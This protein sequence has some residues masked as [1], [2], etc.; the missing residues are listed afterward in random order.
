MKN[1]KKV[2]LID[3]LDEINRVM[4]ENKSLFVRH[5]VYPSAFIQNWS[6]RLV[7]DWISKQYF[8]T[9]ERKEKQ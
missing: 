3:S 4:K 7:S 2:K 8:W 1:F 6:M 9:I 5:K